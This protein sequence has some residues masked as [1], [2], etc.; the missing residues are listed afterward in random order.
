MVNQISNR[1]R[2][3]LR[4]DHTAYRSHVNFTVAYFIY[5][6][7]TY[8]TNWAPLTV[9]NRTCSHVTLLEGRERE[10]GVILLQVDLGVL[11]ER[12]TCNSLQ[13]ID[14]VV[15]TVRDVADSEL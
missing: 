3:K 12:C 2:E 5:H 10:R 15:Y 11:R 9:S 4:I 6:H 7:Q 13:V 1:P 14:Q 8:T